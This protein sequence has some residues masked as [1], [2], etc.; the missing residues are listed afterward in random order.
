MT[1]I[2]LES[3]KVHMPVEMSFRRKYVDEE[4][5]IHGYFWK[6]VPVID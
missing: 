3:V 2:D 5:G 4:K 6:M 1:D